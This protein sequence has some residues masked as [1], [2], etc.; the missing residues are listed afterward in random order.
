MN[1]ILKKHDPTRDDVMRWAREKARIKTQKYKE[2]REANVLPFRSHLSFWKSHPMS[3]M[4][5]ADIHSYLDNQKIQNEA[6]YDG[7]YAIC[8]DL[9]DDVN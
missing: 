5:V 8:T 3:F 9:L 1:F 7:L 6:Q 2:E 4:I